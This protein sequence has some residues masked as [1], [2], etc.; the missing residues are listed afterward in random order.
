[1][2]FTK[3]AVRKNNDQD[4][5]SKETRK[6]PREQNNLRSLKLYSKAYVLFVKPTSIFKTFYR[7]F[8]FPQIN[9]KE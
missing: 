3:W 7:F 2:R 6:G 4:I 1:M 8:K 5:I 9:S